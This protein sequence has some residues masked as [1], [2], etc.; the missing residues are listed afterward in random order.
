MVETQNSSQ[1]SQASLK[2]ACVSPLRVN[3]TSFNYYFAKASPLKA[4]KPHF[5]SKATT[6]PRSGFVQ[7]RT[8]LCLQAEAALGAHSLATALGFAK[9]AAPSEATVW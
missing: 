9:D 3:L 1:I 4:Q 6:S 7:M 5:I 2:D 8:R